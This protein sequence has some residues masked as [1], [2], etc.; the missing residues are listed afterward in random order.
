M[1]LGVRWVRKGVAKAMGNSNW[2][3]GLRAGCIGQWSFVGSFRSPRQGNFRSAARR[4]QKDEAKKSWASTSHGDTASKQL[5]GGGART[6]LCPLCGCT[7][8]VPVI[9]FGSL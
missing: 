8:Q 4:A 3:E 2:S 5:H 6:R 7:A 1:L 9:L